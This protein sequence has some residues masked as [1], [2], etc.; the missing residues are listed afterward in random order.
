MTE[1]LTARPMITPEVILGPVQRRDDVNVH[2][3]KDRRTNRA[4]RLGERE[5]FVVSLMDGRHTTDDISDAYAARFGRRLGDGSWRQIF[6][7]LGDRQLMAGQCDEVALDRLRRD[8]E[9]ISRRRTLLQRRFVLVNPD[10]HLA[11]L[12]RRLSWLFSPWFVLPAVAVAA[13]LLVFVLVRGGDMVHDFTTVGRWG[14]LPVSFPVTWLVVALHESAHGLVCKHFGG[15]VRE[16]GVLWRFPILA[17]FCNTEDTRFFRR[18]RERVFTAFAGVFTSLLAMLPFSVCWLLAEE[19]TWWRG[20]VASIVLFGVAGALLNLTPFLQLDG[21]HM[22]N[23]ALGMDNLRQQSY[24]YWGWLLW[25]RRRGERRAYRAGDHAAYGAYG[26]ATV[27]FLATLAWIM[28]GLWYRQLSGW[29]GPAG[30]VAFLAVEAVLITVFVVY[31]RRR[32]AA[33]SAA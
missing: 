13:G 8:G 32:A 18:R 24:R 33:R 9:T 2:H 6:G 7:M 25:R 20:T 16:I 23:H 1:Q 17:P 31:A 4:Y 19:G 5:F 21:Y 3:L 30:A 29:L 27:A 10:R 15:T 22:V 11:A 28:I 26:L 12:N 14:A